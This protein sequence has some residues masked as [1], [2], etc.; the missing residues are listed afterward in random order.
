MKPRILGDVVGKYARDKALDWLKKE[1][2]WKRDNVDVGGTG[3]DGDEYEKELPSLSSLNRR[4]QE[5]VLK[6]LMAKV[7]RG[8][9]Y[10][11][12]LDKVILS[13]L[14]QKS[15]K[16]FQ[17]ANRWYADFR[18]TG[19]PPTSTQMGQEFGVN[20]EWARTGVVDTIKDLM[21]YLSVDD[22]ALDIADAYMRKRDMGYGSRRASQKK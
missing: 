21:D 14:G 15:T 17:M 4:E 10:A 3:G 5:D 8:D 20:R 7:W 11:K 1:K 9:P 19:K 13:F 22:K 12:Q 18:K 6:E 16:A 2:K